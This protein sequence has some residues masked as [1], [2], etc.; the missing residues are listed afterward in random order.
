MNIPESDF[1][2]NLDIISPLQEIR[3]QILKKIFIH[4]QLRKQSY[5]LRPN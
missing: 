2:K 3:F 4:H 5:L 1:K